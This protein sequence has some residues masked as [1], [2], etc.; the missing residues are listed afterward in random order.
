M[1]QQVV[2]FLAAAGANY[3]LTAASTSLL[4]SALGVPTEAVYL[5]TVALLPIVNFLVLRGGIFHAKAKPEGD[6]LAVWTQR[7][8]RS[9]STTDE[10]A[11]VPVAD[12]D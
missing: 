7:T 6:A 1:H 11:P 5:V 12:G 3:G 10:K 4:P 2:R 9:V 8:S